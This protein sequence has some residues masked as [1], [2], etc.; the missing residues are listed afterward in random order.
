MGKVRMRSPDDGKVY[1]FDAKYAREWQQKGWE[2]ALNTGQQIAKGVADMLPPLAGFAGSLAGGGAG[3]AAG[4]VGSVP[5][6]VLGGMSGG[7]LGAGG[8]Q[9]MYNMAGIPTDQSV[10][11]QL[12]NMA[13]QG[14]REGL[15]GAFS[16]MGSALPGAAPGMMK[17]ALGNAQPGVENVLLKEGLEASPSGL[18][19][20]KL[21]LRDLMERKRQII[22]DNTQEFGRKPL[23]GALRSARNAARS[24]DIVSPADAKALNAA[25]KHAESVLGPRVKGGGLSPLLD[26]FGRQIERPTEVIPAQKLSLKR[27][28]AIRRWADRNVKLFESMRKGQNPTDPGPEEKAYLAVGD[29][30]RGI[31]NRVKT[32]GPNGET[33]GQ[34]NERISNLMNARQALFNQNKRSVGSHIASTVVGGTM[35]GVPAA[36]WSHNPWAGLLAVPGA[37]A[38]HAATSPENLSRMALMAQ[39]PVTGQVL[40][41]SPRALDWGAGLLGIGG[42]PTQYPEQP[43]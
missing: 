21:L 40:G 35:T 7:A 32:G 24:A 17:G 10:M 3:L 8:Q 1:E 38:A 42:I 14:A 26:E 39:N 43:R 2:P 16:G 9:A 34:L 20:A 4:G 28:E 15:F 33:L 12:A 31:I 13:G 36:L 5:G 6:A 18:Q 11:G 27:L 30:A 25:M 19:K 29:A 41:N 37:A 22:G 23:V